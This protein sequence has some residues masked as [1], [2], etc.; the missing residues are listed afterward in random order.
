MVCSVRSSQ[1]VDEENVEEWLQRDE[2]EI[3]QSQTLS[4]LLQN[5][6]VN[7][8]DRMRMKQKVVTVSLIAWQY[9]VLIL[10]LA[11]WV[12]DGLNTWCYPKVPEI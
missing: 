2:C 1:N 10:C 4:T 3:R 12:R 8:M 11:V 7:R 5:R 6:W 9:S